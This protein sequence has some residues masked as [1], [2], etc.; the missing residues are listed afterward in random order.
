MKTAFLFAGQGAQYTGMGKDLCDKFPEADEIFKSATNA[1]G[2]D[3]KELCFTGPDEKL[4]KTENTQPAILTVDIAVSAV[5]K[6][7]GIH[8]DVCAGLSLGEYAALV[9][10]QVFDFADAVRLVRKRGKF[11]QEEVPVGVGAMAAILGLER[12][13]VDEIIKL[14]SNEGIVEG[15]NYNCPG[16]IV[17]S[18]EKKAVEAAVNITGEKGGKAIMLPVSAPFHCSMLKGAGEKLEKEL[19][20]VP[21]NSLKI[22]VFSNVTA[23]YYADDEIKDLLVKQVSSS[24]LWEDIILRMLEEGTETFI[25][26]GPG[27]SLSGFVNKTARKADKKVTTFNVQDMDSLKKLMEYKI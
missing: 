11:M 4:M 27:K 23:G 5:L 18:G 26:I 9:H 19:E 16:Q 10:A 25:E 21:V 24:V 14:A 1:L 12:I 22:P 3:M 2:V 17:I 6:N 7:M 13:V 20:S 8:P 15:A